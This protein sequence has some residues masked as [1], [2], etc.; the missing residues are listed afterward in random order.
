MIEL[1]EKWYKKGMNPPE[2][3]DIEI[4]IPEAFEGF[5]KF[6]DGLHDLINKYNKGE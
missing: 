1:S 5:D 4:K 6:L 3:I 2:Y